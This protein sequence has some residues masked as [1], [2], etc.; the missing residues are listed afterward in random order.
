MIPM[1]QAIR[2]LCLKIDLRFQHN[3]KKKLRKCDAGYLITTPLRR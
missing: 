2:M 1:A 3:P